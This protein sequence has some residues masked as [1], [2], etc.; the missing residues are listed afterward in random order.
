MEKTVHFLLQIGFL[1]QGA[2]YKRNEK[3]TECLEVVE[4][5]LFG[6]ENAKETYNGGGGSDK[7][8]YRSLVASIMHFLVL[9]FVSHQSL[10]DIFDLISFVFVA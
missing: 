6:K 8:V 5:L 2:R 4:L 3:L 1:L 10:H 9:D 7:V